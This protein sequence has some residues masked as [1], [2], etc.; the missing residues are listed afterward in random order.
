MSSPQRVE[1]KLSEKLRTSVENAARILDLVTL[2]AARRNAPIER[3]VDGLMIFIRQGYSAEY[4]I[5]ILES[6]AD[7]AAKD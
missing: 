7:A 4:I 1:L 3:A 2:N 5:A 6:A